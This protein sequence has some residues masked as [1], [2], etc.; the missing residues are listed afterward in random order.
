[1]MAA[2]AAPCHPVTEGVAVEPAVA[3]VATAS[4]VAAASEVATASEVAAATVAAAMPAPTVPAAT[5]A[6]PTARKSVRGEAQSGDGDAYQEHSCCLGHDDLSFR[7][8]IRPRATPRISES[9][10]WLE[11]HFSRIVLLGARLP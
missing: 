2:P 3:E 11:N 6:V 7:H 9:M 4:E 10:S 8:S 5:A 1:M